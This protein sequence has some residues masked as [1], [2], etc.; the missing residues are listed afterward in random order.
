MILMKVI[1]REIVIE[2]Q[3]SVVGGPINGF[4]L[5]PY[6]TNVCL[7]LLIYVCDLV[8]TVLYIP[9]TNEFLTECGFHLGKIIHIVMCIFWHN[10]TYLIHLKFHLRS[11]S[12]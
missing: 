10:E 8:Y 6:N 9:Q 3:I 5:A 1:N 11:K 2:M 12:G 4:A 7:W